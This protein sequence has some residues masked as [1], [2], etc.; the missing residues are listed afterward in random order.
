VTPRRLNSLG[1][2]IALAVVLS[3][4]PALAA[5]PAGPSVEWKFGPSSPFGGTRFDGEYVADQ[6]R[7]YFPGFRTF[8]DITDGSIWYLDG[9]TGTAPTYVDTGIDMP[10]PVSNYQVAPLTD[11]NGLGLY[12][13]SGRDATPTV[14]DTVQVYYPA[15]N[16]TAVIESDPWPGQ[17]P[18]GCPTLPAMGVAVLD[19]KAYVLGGISFSSLGCV[20]DNSAETWVFDPLAPAGSRWTAG[21]PL[22]LARGYIIS[23]V[24]GGQVYAIGG[25]V[26]EAGALFAVQNVEAWDP[27]GGG[28][29][30]DAGVADV[31]VICGESQAFGFETGPYGGGIVLAGCGQWPNAV[32]DTYVYDSAADAWS[33]AGVVNDNRRNHAGV[34]IARNSNAVMY[35]LGGFG[36]DSAFI[37]PITTSEVAGGG[38]LARR[39]P[40][41]REPR[42][43][44]PPGR[45]PGTS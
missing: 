20:D 34:L 8:A 21:P 33:F 9:A 17:S 11:E 14:V 1:V 7:I 10:V 3:G 6:D 41:R 15:T 18:S 22:N 38:P 12:L 19:N 29:W 37:D 23:A 31:P 43:G 13:F 30:D 25:D 32:P 40:D 26:N 28:G 39:R 27:A 45:S 42:A 2:L 36:E 44:G 5:P 35:I 16:T 4:V 24:L